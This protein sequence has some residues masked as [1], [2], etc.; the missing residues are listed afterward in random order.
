MAVFL[1]GIEVESEDKNYEPTFKVIFTALFDLTKKNDRAIFKFAI[2]EKEYYIDVIQDFFDIKEKDVGKIEFFTLTRKE[3]FV[4][5]SSL[6]SSFTLM[7]TELEKFSLMLNEGKDLEALGVL[8]ELS[9]IMHRL[10]LCH[11]LFIV[12]DI[13]MEYNLGGKSLTVYREEIHNM[14]R[15][16]MDAFKA[17]DIVEASDIAEYELAPVIENL[18]QSL[19]QILEY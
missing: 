11:S 7:S 4:K 10:F 6:G 5:M 18:G 19:T 17:K 3:L 15:A 1:D 9:V 2:D 13:P 14:L 12:F 16:I 8:R